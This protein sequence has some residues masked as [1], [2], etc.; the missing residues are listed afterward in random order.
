MNISL[1]MQ[2]LM[3]S[4]A[5]KED[6]NL[7]SLVFMLDGEILDGAESPRTLELEGGECIDVHQRLPEREKKRN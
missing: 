2:I 4:Y 5:D 3:N 7:S 1:Q 6:L